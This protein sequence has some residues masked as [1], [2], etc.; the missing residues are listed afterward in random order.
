MRGIVR[1]STTGCVTI[2]DR[3][4]AA[5]GTKIEVRDDL[6]SRMRDS[7][8]LAGAATLL[9]RFDAEVSACGAGF[10]R[11]VRFSF[12]VFGLASRME[13]AGGSSWLGLPARAH[14]DSDVRRGVLVCRWPPHPDPSP[15]F[16]GGEGRECVSLGV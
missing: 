12:S 10:L 3:A 6:Y 13:S 15:A 2:T 16:H 5:V 14:C 9:R 7:S 1:N 11:S 4:D 8:E